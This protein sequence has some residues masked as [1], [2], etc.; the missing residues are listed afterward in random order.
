[1]Y[2][3]PQEA[4]P[5]SQT[6]HPGSPPPRK[7]PG[8]SCAC[9]GTARLCCCYRETLS[10]PA[11]GTRRRGTCGTL[12]KRRR[13]LL[14][15]SFT[16][17]GC[18]GRISGG[19]RRCPFPR[20]AVPAP[21]A[22]AGQGKRCGAQGY[23]EARGGRLLG[24]HG[25]PRPVTGRSRSTS[26]QPAV[27]SPRSLHKSRGPSAKR[28]RVSIGKQQPLARG[29][30]GRAAWAG[31]GP[32]PRPHLGTQ[33]T[34]VPGQERAPPQPGTPPPQPGSG[35]S[36]PASFTSRGFPTRNGRPQGPVPLRA[37]GRAAVTSGPRAA[38]P[39]STPPPPQGVR[40]RPALARAFSSSANTHFF[41]VA[42]AEFVVALA[43]PSRNLG[44]R[45]APSSR[46]G[47]WVSILF[48]AC[49]QLHAN[50]PINSTEMWKF[51]IAPLVRQ[52]PAD[53]SRPYSTPAGSQSQAGRPWQPQTPLAALAR[54]ICQPLGTAVP[55]LSLCT[56]HNKTSH[57]PW[58]FQLRV[59]LGF[60]PPA[61][62]LDWPRKWDFSLLSGAGLAM[63]RVAGA[64][65]LPSAGSP[66]ASGTVSRPRG[67]Y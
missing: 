40:Q 58:L 36:P 52:A 38:E 54:G 22:S 29:G 45:T 63:Q 64:E 13:E 9:W 62:E 4:L 18:R 47:C 21:A 32:M 25:D 6:G 43:F 11:S 37:A 12:G 5:S 44:R 67:I 35:T 24:Q 19:D 34:P 50:R 16:T 60:A 14:G 46:L 3:M 1:M 61:F 42:I 56:A 28:R 15:G 33:L 17:A 23:G 27:W 39:G 8:R 31:Q 55:R 30:T 7:R 51:C 57:G 53:Q 59:D 66:G 26:C 49:V 10:F 65:V 20:E 41:L 2:S 48:V